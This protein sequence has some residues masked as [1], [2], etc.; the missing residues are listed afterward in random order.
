MK[1]SA[2]TSTD[3]SNFHLLGWQSH[4]GFVR[5]EILNKPVCNHRYDNLR[6]AGKMVEDIEESLLLVGKVLTAGSTI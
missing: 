2:A 1:L 6:I 3:H 4:F 5:G